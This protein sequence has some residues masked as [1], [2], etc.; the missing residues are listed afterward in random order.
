MAILDHRRSLF[1]AALAAAALAFI[2]SH[3]HVI[4]AHAQDAAVDETQHSEAGVIA[5]DNHWSIA[6]LSGDTDWL[7][8][9][10]LADYRSVGNSGAVH[11]KAEIVAG[12]AKRKGTDV[13]KA[14]LDFATYQ[15]EHPYGT[16]VELQGDTAIITFYD[17][18]LGPDKGVK[19]SDVF[20]YIDG[21]WHAMYSQ[22]TAVH[23][24]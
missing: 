9:M 17:T 15:K 2:A 19:S 5:V 16:A 21:H 6:E 22:H 4:D 13:A 12:A 3:P 23:S 1:I 24:G 11:S 18:S 8:H 14:R 10:L 7:D 20:V